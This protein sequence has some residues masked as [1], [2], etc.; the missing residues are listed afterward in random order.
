MKSIF[1]D[2]DGVLATEESSRLGWHEEFA[3]PFDID[4]VAVLN[5]I[6]KNTS[7]EIILTSN[8]RLCLNNDLQLI[9]GLF[10]YNGVYKSPISITRNL[11]NRGEEITS[12]IKTYNVHSFVIWMIWIWTFIWNV[13]SNVT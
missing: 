7:A 4:C 11:N 10:K 8:W 13:L 1:L 5:E 3:Y 2:I 6:L 9:D 12:Y